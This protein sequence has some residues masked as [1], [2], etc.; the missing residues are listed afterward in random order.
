MSKVIVIGAG[1][2]GLFS[3][4][5]AAESGNE[6]IILEK[7][8]ELAL[9][10][11]MSGSGQCNF[12]HTGGIKEF[13][14]HYGD[15]GR[16]AERILRRFDNRNLMEYFLNNG[17][18]YYIREDGKVFPVSRK[19]KD[20]VN[21]LLKKTEKLKIGI[22][23]KQDVREIAKLDGKFALKTHDKNFVCDKVIM[24]TGGMTYPKTGSD[25]FGVSLS[26][27]LGHSVNELKTGLTPIYVKDFELSEIAGVTFE[28]AGLLYMRK[29]AAPVNKRGSL[30]ITHKGF[31]G[32]LI[33]DNSRYFD[34]GCELKLNFTDFNDFVEFEKFI[35]EKA[36]LNGAQTLKKILSGQG[37]AMRLVE[38]MTR[39]SNVDSGKKI[40]QLSKTERKRIGEFLTGYTVKV[41]K[42]GNVNEAMV[43]A[44][45]V[46]F[47]DINISTME[48]RVVDG[49]YF[50]GEMLDI[51]GDTGGYNI[52]MAFSTGFI[53]GKNIG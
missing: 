38:K 28:N 14:T 34:A 21:L 40:S 53:A 52:Q 49:L 10:L 45:G 20:V 41:W 24:A 18:N 4:I 22:I 46:S 26:K 1:P 6:V 13:S 27:I 2:A 30:L 43:T 50:C 47:D 42:L 11:L 3:G 51:D 7:N 29:N 9:K 16:I 17:L 8:S 39:L 15:R 23:K 19:S 31:S 32:P 33:L 12:T 48:S 37:M 35:V 5:I 25:G 44:G 36:A